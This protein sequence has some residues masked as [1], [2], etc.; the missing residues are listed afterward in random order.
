MNLVICLFIFKGTV[1]FVNPII[2]CRKTCE[3]YVLKLEKYCFKLL[4]S[5]FLNYQPFQDIKQ[6]LLILLYNLGNYKKYIF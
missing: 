6:V 3:V 2:P 4:K 1:S 5:V